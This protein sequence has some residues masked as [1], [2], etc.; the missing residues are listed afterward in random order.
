MIVEIFKENK[1]RIGISYLLLTGEFIVYAL[2]P[3]LLGKAVDGLVSGDHA[4]FRFY[5]V[6]CFG[7]LGLGFVRR[8][9][10]NRAFLGIWARKAGRAITSLMFRGV[11]KT[12]IIS[13]AYMV[14][15]FAQ[16]LEVTLPEAL[17][18]IIDIIVALVMLVLLLPL[19]GMSVGAA[20]LFGVFSCYKFAGWIMRQEVTCQYQR[21]QINDA[22][23][24]DDAAAVDA[25]YE[26]QRR[27]YI[28]LADLEA[29]NWGLLDLLGTAAVVA[30]I[31]AAVGGGQS[32]GMIMANA[33]YARKLFERSNLIARF[34]KHL[35]QLR[36]FNSFLRDEPA[37]PEAAV[38]V[39]SLRIIV[40][41]RVEE[42]P[43]TPRGV[44]REETGSRRMPA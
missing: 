21:E 6:V 12:R 23:S 30:V 17:S 4:D 26:V 36:V 1:I 15:E 5:L 31:L 14:K 42:E 13:R 18:A 44:R 37:L 29:V 7:A 40:E 8:R 11:D 2:L 27:N 41:T 38:T 16:F 20:A 22:V 39:Q 34:F 3:F 25:G 19:T 9:F 43:A 35:K 32:V 24:R 10:D 28:H 33:A